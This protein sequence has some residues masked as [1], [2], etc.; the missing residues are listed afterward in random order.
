MSLRVAQV[1]IVLHTMDLARAR[2]V[3][4]QT[5]EICKKVFTAKNA[6]YLVCLDQPRLV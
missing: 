6:K 3:A 5:T 2:K 4:S 1:F